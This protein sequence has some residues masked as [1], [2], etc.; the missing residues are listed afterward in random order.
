MI[1]EN[2]KPRDPSA[3]AAKYC[4]FHAQKEN[5][6]RLPRD[7]LALSSASAFCPPKLTHLHLLPSGCSA[8]TP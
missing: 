8:Y 7:L 2:G 1:E 4:I 5:I 3:R 6:R